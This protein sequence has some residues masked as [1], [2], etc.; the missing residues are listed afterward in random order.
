MKKILLSLMVALATVFSANAQTVEFEWG[1]ASWNIE[2]GKVYEDIEDFNALVPTITYTNPA[3]Y[4]ITMLQPFVVDYDLYIDDSTE[5]I[6][7][8]SSAK[9]M[10]TEVPL[11]Y[12]FQEGHKYK[13][14][15]TSAALAQVNLATYTTDTLSTNSDSYTISFTIKGPELVK[16][17]EVE[18]NMSLSITDQNVDL[19]SSDIN[20]SEICSLLGISDMSEAHVYGLNTDGSYS[21]YD[22]CMGILDGWRDAD[23]GMTGYNGGHYSILGHNDYLPVYCIKLMDTFDQ[24]QYFYYDAWAEYDPEQPDSISGGGIVAGAQKRAPVTANQKIVWDWVDEETGEVYK[25]SRTYRCEE[26]K[27]YKVSYVIIA[28]KKLVRINAT[29]HF[30]SQEAYALPVAS[31]A[32]DNDAVSAI[33]DAS[34]VRQGG[35]K[36]GLNIVKYANGSVKKVLVK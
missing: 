27:D 33:Y 29:L 2:D 28:N 30:L 11:G 6:H 7:T 23:G 34:G 21:P 14:V 31:V 13:V 8:A 19:T 15:T 25:Y 1:T 4:F 16:T 26:G 10:T 18:A 12:P 24:I 20:T 17:I 35:M 9:R 5:P 22:V 32:K 3:S 36:S